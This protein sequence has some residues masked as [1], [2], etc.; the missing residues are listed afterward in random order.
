MSQF[1][2]STYER[3]SIAVS[4][5]L[6]GKVGAAGRALVEPNSLDPE[7]LK[8]LKDR[9]GSGGKHHPI[10]G[11]LLDI[12][13]NPIFLIGMA[14]SLWKPVRS[15]PE[16]QKMQQMAAG[17][18]RKF[19]PILSW[20][21]SPKQL[22]AGYP[23]LWKKMWETSVTTMGIENKFGEKMTAG[24][25]TF[26]KLT[27]R[28]PTQGEW[29][30][31]N[32]KSAGLDRMDGRDARG[33][34]QAGIDV[35]APTYKTISFDTSPVGRGMH[36]LY[37]HQ[38]EALENVWKTVDAKMTP[39][40]KENWAKA[41]ESRGFSV[42]TQIAREEAGKAVTPGGYEEHYFPRMLLRGR[43]QRIAYLES[44][45]GGQ[46]GPVGY[47]QRVLEAATRVIAGPHRT[48]T[49]GVSMI[50]D[51]PALRQTADGQ[52]E[53]PIPDYM[54]A[55]TVTKLRTFLGT[56]KQ[57][58]MADIQQVILS[59]RAG[60]ALPKK[61]QD[62][63]RLAFVEKGLSTQQAGA[64]SH[65]IV[66]QVQS[67]GGNSTKD[68]MGIVNRSM[69]WKGNIPVY[70]LG[71]EVADRY[72]H[73]MSQEVAW[74]LDGAGDAITKGVADIH[75]GA[76]RA[77]MEH[78]V[79]PLMRGMRTFPQS[80]RALEWHGNVMAASEW[81]QRPDIKKAFGP[82]LSNWVTKKLTAPRA[83]GEPGLGTAMTQYFYTTTM[84]FNVG[85]PTKNLM[86]PILT[87]YPLVGAGP[88]WRG[89]VEMMKRTAQYVKNR[90]TMPPAEAKAAAYKEFYDTFGK[91][92]EAPLSSA[93]GRGDISGESQP[94]PSRLSGGG[95]SSAW[96]KFRRYSMAMFSKTERW[97][98]M[99]SFY[100]GRDYAKSSG[101]TSQSE[102]NL[103]AGDI[104]GATQFTAG[105]LGMPPILLN[106]PSLLRQ[107][108]Y[109]PTR[110]AGFLATPPEQ[111]G[112]LGMLGR[113]GMG[114][115]AA[116][117]TAKNLLGVNL[118]PGLAMGAL[119]LPTYEGSPFYPWPLVP[120]ILGV[121]GHL[122]TAAF[123]E[124]PQKRRTSMGQLGALLTPGGVGLRRAY[125][126]TAPKYVDYE[127]PSPDGRYTVFNDNK[128]V[129][130]QYTSTQLWMKRLGLDPVGMQDERE[131]TQYLLAQRNKIREVRQ[132]YMTA[133]ADND[134]PKAEEIQG[135]WKSQFP[136]LG[137][138]TVRDQDIK[139]LVERRKMSRVERILRGVPTQYRDVYARHA[140]TLQG[141]V[142]TDA[143]LSGGGF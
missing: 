117:A 11:M 12:S 139:A 25:R 38:R 27:G 26:E 34:R 36:A 2:I 61:F 131:F 16:L 75:D 124:D 136:S 138:L 41:I 73:T 71:P 107:Y 19:S 17:T 81:F 58:Q 35:Q 93:M 77:T 99:W 90:E 141:A 82:G 85:P 52:W 109:F 137:P 15:L 94:A 37:T 47:A 40:A 116:W 63:L 65:E 119:P 20:I 98:R 142:M 53:A 96:E 18:H 8:R 95:L 111:G 127:N 56:Y 128:M 91:K 108:A 24:V 105:P 22:L 129:V 79:V 49:G 87:L 43:E 110:F 72:G 70:S 83:M 78:G 100:A 120:P 103:A 33:M 66:R 13:T 114:S 44:I 135:R 132:E 80:M 14:L 42:R 21:R 84:G 130:G 50:P 57:K 7:D 68:L 9:L 48:R 115:V 126:L 51:H 121:G 10:I 59:S 32:A 125:R 31:V 67:S 4:R 113:V 45:V 118:E 69:D 46:S 5:L 64:L 1:P 28:L 76:L 55:D 102:M 140:A 112:G 134:T 122:A 88:T 3:P 123:T 39:Q 86:Q 97:N 92:E 106:I 89:F 54:N 62:R 23:D 6:E 30:L 133:L 29:E 143:L 74:T 104:V 60:G 101:I